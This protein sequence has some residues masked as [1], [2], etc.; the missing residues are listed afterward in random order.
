MTK[1]ICFICGTKHGEDKRP[2]PDYQDGKC[3]QCRAYKPITLTKYFEVK[4]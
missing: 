2:V 4:K 3:S 1:F